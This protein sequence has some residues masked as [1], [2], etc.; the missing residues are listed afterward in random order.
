MEMASLEMYEALLQEPDPSIYAW[1]IGREPVPP[2]HDNAV[3]AALRRYAA[4]GP[5]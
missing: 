5:R 2:R 4:S 3:M 1:A